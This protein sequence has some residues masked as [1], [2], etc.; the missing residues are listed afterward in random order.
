M[1]CTP[2]CSVL[3]SWTLGPHFGCVIVYQL[4][5]DA[6]TFVPYSVEAAH[7]DAVLKGKADLSTSGISFVLKS[8]TPNH[9]SILK[10][11]ADSQLAQMRE[12]EAAGG[13][14]GTMFTHV[15]DVTVASVVSRVCGCMYLD[16]VGDACSGLQCVQL[17]KV[18]QWKMTPFTVETK[19]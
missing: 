12:T 17:I 3:N 7:T 13:E 11:L 2:L 19:V 5:H 18:L 4:W 10:V 6:T 9:R 16:P 15:C 8:L 14:V 1:T